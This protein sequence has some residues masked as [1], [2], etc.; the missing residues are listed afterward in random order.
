MEQDCIFCKIIRGEIP[1][2]K[3]YEDENVFVFLDINPV[4]KGH[5]LIIP[6][7]H[8]TNVYD[9]EAED[10]SNVIKTAQKIAITLKQVL[11]MDGVNIHMNNEKSGGQAVF[12]TH[13]HV[14]PR[15]A[16]DGLVHWG[17]RDPYAGN[18]AKELAQKITSL[19]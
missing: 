6:K 18:E 1:S 4:N 8:S 10:L 3:V 5:T 11:N 9:I 17:H 16:D 12:H 2:D 13:I 7:K 19:L 15:Y 14:I